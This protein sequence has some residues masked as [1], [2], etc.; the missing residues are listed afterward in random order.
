MSAT[1]TP[2]TASLL[3]WLSGSGPQD[4][5]ATLQVEPEPGEPVELS[6]SIA[7]GWLPRPAVDV[8]SSWLRQ[9][10]M[11]RF[12]QAQL[13]LQA[14]LE[15]PAFAGV[16]GDQY[17]QRP[18]MRWPLSGE[19]LIIGAVRG[20]TATFDQEAEWSRDELT[21]QLTAYGMQALPATTLD[22][23]HVWTEPSVIA[24]PGALQ[25]RRDSDWQVMALDI[26]RRLGIR[27]VVRVTEGRWEVLTLSEPPSRRF[28]IAASAAC[29]LTR[30]DEHRCPMQ[31]APQVGEYCRMS[32]GPWTSA[33]IDA[34][35]GWR[36]Q[37][38][39]LVTTVGCDTCEGTRHQFQGKIH[40]SGGP[41]TIVNSP[42]PTRWL[43]PDGRRMD[44][45]EG[46]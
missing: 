12:G 31:L 37:R 45:E 3:P 30:D 29:S 11:V 13:R 4:L 7:R 16:Q 15:E 33:S 20:P 39:R 10:T 27:T 6:G 1:S 35:A 5:P 23:R 21:R 34:A 19:L 36:D 44:T 14:R 2:E 17:G 32:G 42:T 8:A 40:S 24:L 25:E 28:D 38:N 43:T 46:H 18:E 9:I 41:I 22:R 26:S